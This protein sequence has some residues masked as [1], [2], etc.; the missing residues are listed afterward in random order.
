MG[1]YNTP[2]EAYFGFRIVGY[3]SGTSSFCNDIQAT[4]NTN[5]LSFLNAG[6]NTFTLYTQINQYSESKNSIYS[7]QVYPHN[8][9]EGINTFRASTAIEETLYLDRIQ[10]LD[11]YGKRFIGIPPPVI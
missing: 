8:L 11:S 1:G 9:R 10:L 2:Q 7:G 3:C 4:T 5:L 6:S